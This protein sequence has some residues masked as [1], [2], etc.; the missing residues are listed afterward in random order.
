MVL[1]SDLV[2]QTLSTPVIKHFYLLWAI[3]HH[4]G[5]CLDGF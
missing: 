5:W 1:F 4:L 2:L 3:F